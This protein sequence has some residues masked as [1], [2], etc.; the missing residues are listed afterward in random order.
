MLQ[1]LAAKYRPRR[2]SD[3]AGQKAAV[4]TVKGMF[5]TGRIAKAF[6]IEGPYGSGKTSMG[7]LISMRANCTRPEGVDPCGKCSS[8]KRYLEDPPDHPCHM[9]INA[10]SVRGIDD[11]RELDRKSRYNPV[12][13]S[14]YRVI[15]LDEPQG[16]TSP[17][18]GALLKP[19]E[20][21]PPTTIWILC[22]TDPHKLTNT[23]LSRCETGHLSMRK[24]TTEEM[25]KRLQAICEKEKMQSFDEKTLQS[26]AIAADN[27]PRDAISIL[28]RLAN[29]LSSLRGKQQ[30]NE[31]QIRE[32]LLPKIVEELQAGSPDQ[33][34]AKAVI[35][36]LSDN[37]TIS[38]EASKA[39]FEAHVFLGSMLRLWEQLLLYSATPKLMN[40]YYGSVIKKLAEL[41]V[42][43][44]REALPTL[45]RAGEV[46]TKDYARAKEYTID[47]NWL[48][49]STVT[50]LWLACEGLHP[51]TKKYVG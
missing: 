45:L 24:V 36:I 20:E 31:S 1:T 16:L 22:T 28:D 6:L 26:I 39:N 41:K 3:F 5:S 49:T 43:L 40:P 14:Q 42:L 47:S 51:K 46:L 18:Q 7:R 27:H 11:I 10:S 34:A 21:P 2:L 19:L 44:G 13:G 12:G 9:E 37:L 4:R 48:K 32:S 8:C 23:I 50:T 35:G 17:A 15:M 33:I 25:T 38:L 29:Y 30:L